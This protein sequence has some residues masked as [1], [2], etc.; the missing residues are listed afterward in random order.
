MKDSRRLGRLLRL[1]VSRRWLFLIVPT[2]V[3]VTLFLAGVALASA[4]NA[5]LFILGA[6]ALVSVSLIGWFVFSAGGDETDRT[7]PMAVPPA[8]ADH[9]VPVV[10]L[11]AR[12]RADEVAPALFSRQCYF[13]VAQGGEVVG[14]LSKA[15]LLR[16]VANGW[17]D[18][19]IV[20]LMAQTAAATECEVLSP[21][22]RGEGTIQAPKQARDIFSHSEDVGPGWS[23]KT[24]SRQELQ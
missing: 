18:R 5:A 11:P 17:G 3:A 4:V 20:E 19:L 7:S 22:G 15:A 14:V 6:L 16:A 12:A 21:E 10:F 2:W 9:R 1:G 8:T 13:P 24:P 23:W